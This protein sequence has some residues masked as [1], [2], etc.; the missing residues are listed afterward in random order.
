MG[1]IEDLRVEN[2][3]GYPS[4]Y[5]LQAERL[6]L[7][8]DVRALLASGLMNVVV[9]LLSVEKLTVFYEKKLL[10]SNI[11]DTI[12]FLYYGSTDV[13]AG[14]KELPPSGRVYCMH[15]WVMRDIRVV[16]EGIV[17]GGVGSTSLSLDDLCYE[18]FD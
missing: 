17:C 10:T 3:P 6:T 7:D 15:K 8:I 13:I 5:L 18:D 12:H 11:D 1:N 14:E 4:A 9:Q 16:V 2:P